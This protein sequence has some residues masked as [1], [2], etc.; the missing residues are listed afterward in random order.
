MIP[1]INYNSAEDMAWL[2]AYIVWYLTDDVDETEADD[3]DDD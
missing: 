1:N 2:N 3:E